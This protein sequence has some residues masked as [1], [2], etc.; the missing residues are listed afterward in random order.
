MSG[1]C[2][3]LAEIPAVHLRSD[4]RSG[5]TLHLFANHGVVPGAS[6]GR[7]TI[8]SDKE[9]Q[10]RGPAGSRSEGIDRKVG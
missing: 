2:S 5:R 8:I 9:Y 4:L 6:H 7:W 10:V 1:S 3:V